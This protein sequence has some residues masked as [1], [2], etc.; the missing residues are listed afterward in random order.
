MN[1]FIEGLLR[2][3]RNIIAV[4]LGQI[5]AALGTLIGVR[6]VTQ[7]VSPALFGEY[8]LLLAGISLVSGVCIRPFIQFTMREYHDAVAESRIYRFLKSTRRFFRVYLLSLA[9]IIA[10][11]IAFYLEGR[12]SGSMSVLYL[13]L[14]VLVV[15]SN[16]ELNRA[17]M[18]T[19]NAQMSATAV[20]IARNWLVP[21]AIVL[22]VLVFEQGT[23]VILMATILVLT[24]LWLAQELL[25]SDT[26]SPAES[27]VD[28][29]GFAEHFR[30]ALGFAMPLALVG[31][32][33]W[34]VHE[35]DRFFLSYYH[36]ERVVGIYSAAYGLVSAPFTL[37]IGSMAQLLYPLVFRA[38]SDGDSEHRNNLLR[39]M[40]IV[41]S[42]ICGV[43]LFVVGLFDSQIA[44]LALGAAYREEASGL[45]FWIAFGY[46]LHAVAM[47]FDLAAY[48]GKKTV[49]IFLSYGVAA[50]ANVIFN[51]V[52]I[53]KYSAMG[54]VIATFI[55]LLL[56]LATMAA[57]FFIREQRREKPVDQSRIQQLCG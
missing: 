15:A 7:Y 42:V 55:S 44:W 30:G 17:L 12:E 11:P 4:L 40:L 29:L 33:S 2:H 46:G 22:G 38:S 37:L 41:S 25:T 31:V 50:L 20:S 43:G 18:T 14:I 24:S 8:K 47:S 10:I 6:L 54:A 1:Q 51:I 26:S 21:P 45:L 53:P 35:S 5:I 13:M 3:K 16:V 27:D 19:R 52:L 39:G 32:L 57:L 48:G 9:A 36:S 49:D 56:Y 23:T 28:F 34:L